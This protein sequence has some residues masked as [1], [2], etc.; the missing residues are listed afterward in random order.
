M[1]LDDIIVHSPVTRLVDIHKV[2][3]K[4]PYFDVYIGRSVAYTEFIQ[5]S[6][7]ANPFH[8]KDWGDQAIPKYEE[9][10]RQKIAENPAKYNIETLRDKCLG[11]WCISTTKASPLRCHGQVLIKILNESLQQFNASL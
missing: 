9:Y 11:C 6:I 3:G 1:S 4:R 10:I 5:D 7:W 8:V 2:N